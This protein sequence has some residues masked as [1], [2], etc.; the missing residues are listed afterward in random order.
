MVRIAQ[1]VGADAVCHGSTGAGNDQV[2]FDVAFRV[3]A[4]EMELMSP[5]RDLKWSRDQ[6][7]EYLRSA[8]LEVDASTATYSVNAGMW[9]TTVGGGE[10]HDP[11]QGALRG[12][13][14]GRGQQRSPT[15]AA[16]AR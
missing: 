16:R 3:L 1:E 8:G 12:G 14:D 4:P 11:A 6:E 7:A 13:V 9:G 15:T 2:R 5:V 10:I